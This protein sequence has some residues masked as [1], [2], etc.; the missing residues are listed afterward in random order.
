MNIWRFYDPATGM[1]LPRRVICPASQLAWNTPAGTAPYRGDAD[2]LSQRVDVAAV[3][4]TDAPDDWQPPLIDY[5]PPAPADDQWQTWSWDA[6]TKRWVSTPTLAAIKR[7]AKQAMAMAW[8]EAR[9]AGVTVGGK[10]APTDADSWTRYL[11]IKAMAGDGGWIDVPIPL[12]DGTFELLT[13]TKAT[14]LWTALKD[15]ER[16]L[17]ARLRDRVQ[18]IDAAADA[19]AVAAVV[20]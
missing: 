17:L 18:A 7:D 12:T 14:A 10:L 19:A 11:A 13:L 20:W 15:M 3:P 1:L 5:Q 16:T 2:P 8:D 9:R 6:G 4:P